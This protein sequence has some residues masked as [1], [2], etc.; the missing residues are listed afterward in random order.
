ME[1]R[2]DVTVSQEAQ[3]QIIQGIAALKSLMPFLIK[4]QAAD[5]EAMQL[6]S[7]GRKPFVEKSYDLATRNPTLD[8]GIKMAEEGLRD[9]KLFSFLASVEN[10]LLQLVEMV[11][12]TKQLAGA[13]S[14][15]IARFIYS[16]AK[17]E[18]KM[19]TPGM[20]SVVDELGKLYKVTTA[21]A[22]GPVV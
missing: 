21:P 14:Y 3:D 16:K 11:R 4:L 5:R 13:E 7:D 22:K 19:G 8:P 12:D 6:L 1:N 18:L 10:E 17:M 20:Q 2:I 9:I 15:V